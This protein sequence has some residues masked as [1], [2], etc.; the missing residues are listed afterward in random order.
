[1]AAISFHSSS[2]R[3]FYD[4][5]SLQPHRGFETITVVRHG[6][7]DHHDSLGV[8]GRFGG[9]DTQY[10]TAGGL[11]VLRAQFWL[12]NCSLRQGNMPL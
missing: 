5:P 12:S 6:Y 8:S 9:G 10:M 3:S 7:V 1:M 2:A 11:T 4:F